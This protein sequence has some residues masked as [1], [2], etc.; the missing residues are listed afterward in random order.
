[1]V[2]TMFSGMLAGMVIGMDAAMMPVAMGTA[3]REGAVYGLI[4]IVVIWI[5]NNTIRGVR[6]VSREV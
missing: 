3:A 4:G 6:D 5:F 2:S 1:M